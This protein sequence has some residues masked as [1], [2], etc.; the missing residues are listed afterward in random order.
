MSSFSKTIEIARNLQNA[1]GSLPLSDPTPPSTHSF[2]RFRPLL[3]PSPPDLRPSLERLGLAPALATALA[4]AYSRQALRSRLEV[5]SAF[6]QVANSLGRVS[7]LPGLIPSSS[8]HIETAE[9]I[10]RERYNAQCSSL[11]KVVLDSVA[12]R[13]QHFT[14][15]QKRQQQYRHSTR[16]GFAKVRLI[17]LPFVLVSTFS[18]SSSLFLFI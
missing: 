12:R 17:L 13:R 18:D 9:R 11:E 14:Q 10:L 8:L 6:E 5:T 1:C 7:N 15:V 16:K 2:Q 3:L 4:S